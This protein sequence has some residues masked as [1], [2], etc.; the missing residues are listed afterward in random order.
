MAA[1]ESDVT[2]LVL[3]V[4]EPTTD[5]AIASVERQ[6]PAPREIIIIRDLRPF[7]RA[8]NA[9]A[10]KVRTPHFVQVDADMILDPVCIAML[11]AEMSDDAGIVVGHLRDELIGDVVGIKMF[12]TRCFEV[13]GFRNSISPDTDF[14]KDIA[15]AGWKT[16]HAG[17]PAERDSEDWAMFGDHRPDYTIEYTYK[18]YLLEGRRYRYRDRIGGIRWHF[19]RLEASRHPASLAAQIGLARG[20]F[21]A[22]EDDR[23]GTL[24][25]DGELEMLRAFMATSEAAEASAVALPRDSSPADLFSRCYRIGSELF[26]GANFATFR[27]TVGELHT[28][29]DERGWIA[30]VALCQGLFA[31]SLDETQIRADWQ[32]LRDFMHLPEIA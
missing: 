5:R 22:L 25:I 3:S 2:A 26:H 9:G 12:R 21:L 16:V 4:G 8:L 17:A 14:G 30:K 13:L 7:H 31:P 6:T 20:I 27:R 15:E 19:G 18:K 23:L 1:P 32:T 28:R 10:V 24:C 29:K 11:R